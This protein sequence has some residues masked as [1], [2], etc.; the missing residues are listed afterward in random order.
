MPNSAK[1]I[2]LKPISSWAANKRVKDMHYSGK[3]S[4]TTKIHLGVFLNGI[5]GGVIQYG[6]GI[7]KRKL[8]GLVRGT[9]WNEFLE[10]NRLV[11]A[12]WMPRNGESRAISMSMKILKRTYPW[13]KWV[14]SF[15]DGCQCG[16]GTI[17]RASGFVLTGIRKNTTMYRLPTGEVIADIITRQPWNKGT[18]KRLGF[19]PTDTWRSFQDRVGAEKLKGYQ[20]RYIY[21]LKSEEKKNLTVPMIPFAEI[22]KRK[23]GMFR[24]RPAGVNG[25]TSSDQEESGGSSPTAGL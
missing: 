2:I 12:D 16:D 4:T 17:Y 7:D 22:K 19:L 6:P 10:L 9:K 1:D 14:V 21:F 3:V 11:M 13:I 15:A 8:I 20:F 25:S 24:G 23:I 18:C 5:C